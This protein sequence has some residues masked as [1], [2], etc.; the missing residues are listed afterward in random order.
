MSES[1]LFPF[2]ER[3]FKRIGI[4]INHSAGDPVWI[5]AKEELQQK[6]DDYV[7]NRHN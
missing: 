3:E 4:K 7:K 1:T 5:K 2:F 6:F